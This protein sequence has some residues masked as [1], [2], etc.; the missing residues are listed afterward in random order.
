[1]STTASCPPAISGWISSSRPSATPW[2]ASAAVNHLVILVETQDAAP[3]GL[4][5]AVRAEPA[6]PV[7]PRARVVEF[8]QGQLGE[9]CHGGQPVRAERGMGDRGDG[10][11]EQ[12][13]GVCRGVGLAAIADGEVDAVCAQVADLVAGGEPYVEAADGRAAGCPGAAATRARPR[14]CSAV[15]VT[16]WRPSRLRSSP[17]TSWSCCTAPS[18]LPRNSRSPS[19]V[20]ATPRCWRTNS[21]TCR[22]SSSARICRLT[23]DCVG[24]R[25]SAAWVML[26]RRP[27][28]RSP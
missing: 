4:P 6:A 24:H 2:P 5:V 28:P 8:E 3:A 15:T 19:G 1:M 18:A 27:R 10:F 16:G 22:W 17:A 21:R 14:R 12:A 9:V 23:A 13:D 25:S 26:M 7:Q 11:V 20:K